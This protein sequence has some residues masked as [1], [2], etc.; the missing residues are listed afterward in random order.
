[1][2]ARDEHDL[3]PRSRWRD[4][5]RISL[6]LDDKR[7]YRHCFELREAALRRSP[8]GL[9]RE[10]EA[11]NTDGAGRS[12]RSARDPP[13]ER[14]TADDER[15]L[16]DFTGYEVLD[17]RDERSVE[18]PGGCRWPPPRHP[19]RL[20]DEGDPD[21]LLDRSI[22]SRD[23]IGRLDPTGRTVPEHER[24]AWP[25]SRMHV[26]PGGTVRGVD[27]DDGHPADGST[28]TNATPAIPGAA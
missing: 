6:A 25:L 15:E 14:A 26:P 23:E 1:V 19:V 13:A 28:V 17:D 4:S 18:L 7:P 12:D 5:E 21:T 16:P 2:I 9:K 20:L 22:A 8:E 27:L 24:R 11:E 3:A 10:G